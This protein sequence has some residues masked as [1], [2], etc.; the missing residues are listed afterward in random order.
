MKIIG[1]IQ[2]ANDE[3]HLVFGWASVADSGGKPIA[4]SEGDIINIAEL[5]R[6]AYDFVEFSREGGEMH[7]RTGVATLIESM[8]FTPEK[9]SALGLG[10]DALPH[11]WFI[12]LRVTDEGVW[13]K[14]KDGTYTMFSIAGHAVREAVTDE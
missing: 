1:K 6:A 10:E 8:V 7:Q 9:L 3:Q 5:E 4:D 11:G 12:G 14:I 13:Q 2:K